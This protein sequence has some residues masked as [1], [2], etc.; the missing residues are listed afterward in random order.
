MARDSLDGYELLT[1]VTDGTVR[2]YHAL[3]K[4][5]AVVMVHFVETSPTDEAHRALALVDRLVPEERRKVLEVGESDGA[6]A[7]ATKFILDFDSFP[8]WLSARTQAAVEPIPSLDQ[9]RGELPVERPAPHPAAEPGEF[10][11][12]FGALDVGSPLL[13]D[14]RLSPS[15]PSAGS[16]GA[17]GS[18]GSTGSAEALPGAEPAGGGSDRGDQSSPPGAGTG[19]PPSERPTEPGEFTL[20]FRAANAAPPAG[21]PIGE[22]AN[23]TVPP[24]E[25]DF[26]RAFKALREAELRDDTGRTPPGAESDQGTEPAQASSPGEFTRLFKAVSPPEVSPSGPKAPPAPPASWPESVA[27][28]PAPASAPASADRHPSA[29][30]PPQDLPLPDLP[31][32]DLPPLAPSPPPA[33]PG[34]PPPPPP[35]SELVQAPPMVREAGLGPPRGLPTPNLGATTSPEEPQ[36][37]LPDLR[38]REPSRPSQSESTSPPAE[39]SPAA[40]EGPGEFTKIFGRAELPK[41]SAPISPSRPPDAGGFG[42]YSPPDAPQS[43]SG[44][45][46][47]SGDANYL[48]RLAGRPSSEHDRPPVTQVPQNTPIRAN[49]PPP[50]HTVPPWL[51]DAKADERPIVASGPSEYTRVISAQ[52]PPPSM[53]PPPV[54]PQTLPQEVSASSNATPFLVGIVIVVLL[55]IA[56]ILFFVLRSPPDPTAPPLDAPVEAAPLEP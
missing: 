26:T 37:S 40:G 10:T 55:T 1:Q 49:E 22:S 7:I 51:G 28:L 53:R 48:D 56:L 24:A 13:A 39:P 11:R 17:T 33:M 54:E 52:T 47:R 2:T 42:S 38:W 19:H 20:A 46:T 32:P 34:L 15:A 25:G 29:P 8:A 21:V 16:I 35:P 36:V 5:G 3:A 50:D 18:T 23:D 44:R 9:Q 12:E 30:V 45:P 27:D 41:H 14:G 43:G 4:T 6:I 31:L